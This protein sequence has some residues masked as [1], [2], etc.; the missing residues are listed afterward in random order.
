MKMWGCSEVCNWLRWLFVS[1]GLMFSE[2]NRWVNTRNRG[3]FA[4]DVRIVCV[5]DNEI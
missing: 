2:K 1:L 5:L 3:V 4:Y